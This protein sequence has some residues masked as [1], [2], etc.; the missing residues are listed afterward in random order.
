M[1]D[2]LIARAWRIYHEATDPCVV[3]PALPILFFGDSQQYFRSQLRV[4]TVGKNPSGKEFPATDF[5]LRFGAVKG[6]CLDTFSQESHTSYQ[7]ALNG[8]FRNNPYSAWFDAY[9]P[10]LNGMGASYYAHQPNVALHTDLC[11]PLATDPT[12]SGLS[13]PQQALLEPEGARLWHDLIPVLA[14][15]VVIISVAEKHLIKVT[16]RPLSLWET[17]YTVA[18][19][20]TRNKPYRVQALRVTIGKH[21]TW[22]I[23][24]RSAQTPL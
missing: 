21:T 24:G 5:L 11:S 13:D 1:F 23:F 17:I 8:Y 2:E 10:L 3:K 7:A 22:M 20:E 19:P 9:E 12:W 4:V 6:I 18:E 14:P 15:H 16:D